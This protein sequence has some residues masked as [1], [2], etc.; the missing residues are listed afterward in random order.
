MADKAWKALERRIARKFNTE[1]TPLS[2]PN[3]KHTS[4]G[5]EHEY[6]QRKNT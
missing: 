5:E 1:S 4:N 6:P 3:G 2:S